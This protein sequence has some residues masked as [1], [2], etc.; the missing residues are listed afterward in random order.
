MKTTFPITPRLIFSATAALALFLC[1]CGN[2]E[3]AFR[4]PVLRQLARQLQTSCEAPE[5]RYQKVVRDLFQP[6]LSAED[7][8]FVLGDSCHLLVDLQYAYAQYFDEPALR[9]YFETTQRGDTL[10]AAPLA[11]KR[12]KVDIQEEKIIFSRID[13]SIQYLEVRIHKDQFLYE[14]HAHLAL[15][16]DSLGRYIRHEQE[17]KVEVSGGETYHAETRG[18]ASYR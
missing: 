12:K 6:E 11:E 4:H 18:E 10:V 14:L 9:G 7:S 16:F 1:S 13:S 3:T 5:A 15:T 2:K 8:L 17:V